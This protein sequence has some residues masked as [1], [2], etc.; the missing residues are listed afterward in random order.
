MGPTGTSARPGSRVALEAGLEFLDEFAASGSGEVAQESHAEI[1]RA[2]EFLEHVVAVALDGQADRAAGDSGRLDVES[3]EGAAIDLVEQVLHGATEL[4]GDL[5]QR[6][7]GA[8]RRE[9]N[10]SEEVELLGRH[11]A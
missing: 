3:G 9:I 8:P 7:A 1:D 10:R 5:G 2:G 4:G 6:D 11:G